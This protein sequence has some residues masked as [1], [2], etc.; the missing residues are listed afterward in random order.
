MNVTFRL[1]TEELESTFIAE[2]AIEGLQ[3]LKGHRSVGGVRASIYN[4]CPVE[5]VEALVAFMADFENR[6]G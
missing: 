6:H 5:A 2:A 3:A 4:A 1:T